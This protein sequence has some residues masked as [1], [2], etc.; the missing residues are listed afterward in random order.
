MFVYLKAQ[1]R[2]VKR[3]KNHPVNYRP[4]TFTMWLKLSLQV[5]SIH[6]TQFIIIHHQSLA[7]V[8][9]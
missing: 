7:L 3:G 8:F 5:P 1:G 6:P 4:N 2:M 9:I